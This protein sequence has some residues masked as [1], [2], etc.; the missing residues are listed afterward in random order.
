VSCRRQRGAAALLG[1][2][3]GLA[4]IGIVAASV[5]LT[6]VHARAA[7]RQRRQT[8]ARAAAESGAAV[9]LAALAAGGQS[10]RLS[11][12]LRQGSYRARYR[13]AATGFVVESTGEATAHAGLILQCTIRIMGDIE[14]Q[15]PVYRSF[16][17]DTSVRRRGS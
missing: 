3:F 5:S 15:R 2:F 14:A 8:E 17:V 10:G 6:N 4:M 13:Q 7:A 12:D 1:L 11:K 9:C 16:A